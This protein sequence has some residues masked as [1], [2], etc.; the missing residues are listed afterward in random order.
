MKK[1]LDGIE[2][3]KRGNTLVAMQLLRDNL[4]STS[5]PEAKAWYGYCLARE[6]RDFR[7]AI[8]LCNQARQKKPD[9]S[10]ICLALGRIYLLA[11]LRHSAV[12]ALQT[13][14]NLDNNQETRKLLNSIGVRKPP[15]FRFLNRD[16]KINV[17]SGRLFSKIG[18][19]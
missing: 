9:S 6:N 3:A 4:E 11:G 10:D 15:V 14:L 16:S 17:A 1:T 8:S 2:E 12:K 18:L 13:G 5:L 7:Q 19:R